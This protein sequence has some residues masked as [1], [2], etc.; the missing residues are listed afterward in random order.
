MPDEQSPAGKEE[1][2][3]MT[4]R[5]SAGVVG[6]RRPALLPAVVAGALIVPDRPRPIDRYIDYFGAR[7]RRPTTAWWAG[8]TADRHA[9]P[10]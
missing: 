6:S 8:I 2:V 3:S 10:G 9:S 1:E 7:V 4:E 5:I